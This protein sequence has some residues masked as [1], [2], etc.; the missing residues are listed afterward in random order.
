MKI[1]IFLK[2]F[3]PAYKAG[4]PIV[5]ISNM[6][7]Y[8]KGKYE[9]Y[10]VTSNFDIGDSN[11]CGFDLPTNQW[12]ISDNANIRYLRKEQA[13]ISNF[14]QVIKEVSP[15]L[16]Y[17]NSFF[18]FHFSIKIIMAIK[19][20]FIRHKSPL[21]L[22]PRGE[23]SSGA[24]A[25]KPFRKNVYIALAKCLRLCRSIDWHASSVLEQNNIEKA[26]TVSQ[27]K[28][29]VAMDLPSLQQPFNQAYE[30][31]EIEER[32][33]RFVFISRISPM[34]NLEFVLEIL[35]KSQK[36]L[37]LDIYGPIEDKKYWLECCRLIAA[38][39]KNISIKYQGELLPR[40]VQSTF[41]KYDAFIFP[42]KGENYGHV[43]AESLMAGTFVITSDQTPWSE[44]EDHAVGIICGLQDRKKWLA[45]I[46]GMALLS[47]DQK[48][49]L[50]TQI[51]SYAI[52]NIPNAQD[53][54]DNKK[55]FSKVIQQFREDKHV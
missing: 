9:F 7:A 12:L 20:G 13:N 8:L 49:Q 29:H 55:L 27:Q 31:L 37:T 54:C 1:L 4:G 17:L 47:R 2:Y 38:M 46:D 21:L 41:S 11:K 52:H 16:I 34:K 22:A 15:D 26:F 44:L 3:S 19:V 39:P 25:L 23:F 30:V 50:R 42:T 51:Y 45:A 5:T 32:D 14:R 33:A 53:V 10:I 35:Q 6:M 24:L 43:I 40:D 48:I 28:I 36:K 18:D